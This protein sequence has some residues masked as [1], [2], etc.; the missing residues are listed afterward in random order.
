MGDGYNLHSGSDIIDLK[1]CCCFLLIFYFLV[2]VISDLQAQ[3][4]CMLSAVCFLSPLKIKIKL[5]KLEA[6]NG[7]VCVHAVST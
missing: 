6:W 5:R 7:A 4:Y 2:L 1:V 3:A